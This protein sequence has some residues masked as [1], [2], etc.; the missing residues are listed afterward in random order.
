VH[1]V[2]L[3]YLTLPCRRRFVKK[4]RE[5]LHVNNGA[6]APWV[7]RIQ[8]NVWQRTVSAI[9]EE[10]SHAVLELRLALDGLQ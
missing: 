4:L 1:G 5:R 7:I 9:V 2:V 3:P 10:V 6:K 8:A